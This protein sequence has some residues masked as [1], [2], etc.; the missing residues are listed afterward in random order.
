MLGTGEV[1]GAGEDMKKSSSRFQVARVDSQADRRGSGDND[2]DVEHD[3]SPQSGPASPGGARFS[4][5][6]LNFTYDT[7]NKTC[8][9]RNTH[10]AIPSE[11]HYRNIFSATAGLKSRPTLAELHEEII[12]E[13]ND[14]R[15]RNN[16]E[17][18]LGGQKQVDA[19][20][21]DLGVPEVEP[22]TKT[23]L[24]KF[25]WI[26]GVFI[27]CLL[28][29]WGVM[30]FIRL[31]WCVAHA[32]VM[33]VI[34]IILLSG[35][36]TTI[37]TISMSAI[38]TNGVVKGGGAYFLISRS[39]GPE[40]G[41][42]IGL[43]F[44][45]ANAVA[46]AMY[47]VG[48]AETAVALMEMHGAEMVNFASDIRIIGI[49]TMFVLF[50][51]T[52]VGMEWES[53]A[54]IV[55]LVVL[56]IALVNFVIGT[57]LP[58]TDY[59][60]ARGFT[61]FSGTTF[62]ANFLPDF[63]GSESFASV[64]SV[65][66]PAATGILAGANISGDL[67]DPQKAIPKG[68][69]Y[70]IIISSIVYIVVAGM[71][72]AVLMRDA[73]G[74]EPAV[75]LAQ[76]LSSNTT[77]SPSANTTVLVYGMA[78]NDSANN[79]FQVPSV[80]PSEYVFSPENVANCSLMREGCKYGLFH[81]YQAMMMISGYGYLITAGIFSAT[82][83]SALASMVSAPKVFQ[84]V[85]K[86]G[87]FPYLGWFSAVSAKSEMPYRAFVLTFFLGLCF[88]CIGDL[89]A[90][91][92]MIS[93]FF[94]A[95]YAL[96]NFSCFDVALANPPGWRPAFRYYN[97]WAS[98]VGFL[99][100]LVV[101][102][103]IQWMMALG[104]VLIIGTAFMYVKHV[105]PD[106]NWGSS[107]QAHVYRKALKFSLKLLRTEDHIKNF[108]PQVLVL[109]G[110][111]ENRPALVDFVSH[112]TKNVGL[113]VCGSVIIGKPSDHLRQI[114]SPTA[115]NFFQR[116]KARSFYSCAV[117]P[118]F[119]LGVQSLLQNVGIGKFRPNLLV[120]GFKCNW[121]EDTPENVQQYFSTIHDA[122]DLHYGVGILRMRE[123]LGM[124][125]DAG[126][127]T[128]FNDPNDPT[129]PPTDDE[130]SLSDNED[131]EKDNHHSLPNGHESNNGRNAKPAKKSSKDTSP[132]KRLETVVEISQSRAGPKDGGQAINTEVIR[133]MN[134]FNLKKIP[135][136]TI[137]VWWLYDDGG[138][139]LLVPYL[140]KQ[141]AWKKCPIRIFVPGTRKGE[142]DRIQREL[143][144]ML[145]KFRL[146]AKEVEVLP[147]IN[148]VPREESIRTFNTYFQ[149][150][151]LDEEK[152]ETQEEFP[153]K[154]TQAEVDLLSDKTKRHIRLREL[155]I[156]RSSQAALIVMTLPMPRKGTCSAGLYMSW[157]DTLTRDMPPFLLLRGNQQSVLTFYS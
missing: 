137:D 50:A 89:N 152:G 68:T 21:A 139:T 57:F 34:G 149:P 92:P 60:L 66:F 39:L 73:N 14:P 112:V 9:W 141:K 129:P 49:I 88:T 146:T 59:K 3:D 142:I 36:V 20:L 84:A 144:G 127:A 33:A 81:D 113:M 72:G 114:H 30:L 7:A 64:F 22:V 117:A 128:I 5:S 143:V 104:C 19:E 99:I 109:T 119:R 11:D 53:R 41:G 78:T 123:G 76:V 125:L 23:A 133:A 56:L 61:G 130:L 46:V 83:S 153:W 31:A 77:S 40:F 35:C 103:L 18:L 106:V 28:N 79:T 132:Q 2:G 52:L 87:I 134:R 145:Q 65:F 91:A 156:E 101:M 42:P 37:T 135:G 75:L 27:R 12:P 80:N 67:R 38:C 70:A 150:W 115:Y 107:G 15:S 17:P 43:V 116:R 86:D 63:R 47:V 55:L 48:F 93:M 140:L 74:F 90:I 26:Q 29:I 10:E 6:S 136:G 124:G 85:C 131:E 45:I 54:Q 126:D 120:M 111:P 25:G 24:V 51:I 108:R 121:N 94:L 58:P 1:E 16:R 151:L 98:L 97:K 118:N 138:L 69:L 96:I 82:L 157:V 148:K 71:L 155:L 32:G 13:D 44:S 154:S 122:F 102:F 105:K 110:E 147:E 4:V 95:T 100:C 8:G 62:K